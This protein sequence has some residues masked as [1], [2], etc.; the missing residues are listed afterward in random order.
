MNKAKSNK[1]NAGNAAFLHLKMGSLLF[2]IA[3]LVEH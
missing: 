2:L 3:Y 1:S